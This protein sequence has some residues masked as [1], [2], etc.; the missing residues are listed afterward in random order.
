MLRKRIRA[1]VGRIRWLDR[2]LTVR[3]AREYERAYRAT[4]DWYHSR[5]VECGLRWDEAE[6]RVRVLA[7]AALRG[8]APKKW[9]AVHAFFIDDGGDYTAMQ[10]LPA[11]NRAG[12]CTIVD[13]KALAGFIPA[14]NLGRWKGGDPQLAAGLLKQIERAQVEQALDVI[15]CSNSAG[16][17]SNQAVAELARLGVPMVS[18]WSDDKT[19]FCKHMGGVWGNCPQATL[20]D[21]CW[22]TSSACLPWYAVEGGRA[23][24]M[25]E[26]AAPETFH[27][28]IPKTFSDEVSF[29]GMKYGVRADF[30]SFLRGRGIPVATYGR[31]WGGES[32]AWQDMARVFCSSRINLGLPWV[33]QS[34][35]IAH[36][37]GRDFEVPMSGGLYLTG[38]HEE[39]SRHY[40]VGQEIMCYGSWDGCVEVIRHLV[41]NPDLA[42]RIRRAGKQRALRDHTWDARFKKLMG[43]MGIIGETQNVE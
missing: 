9:G 31:G 17:L 11:L 2:L 40:R 7:R 37:K 14:G 16:V 15:F 43:F 24:C 30:I 18:Y 34:R 12:R 29:L 21:L 36:L 39:L 38:Y 19:N 8:R 41:A 5:A 33:T 23:I 6:T 28:E 20:F 27:A 1:V 22:T 3:R 4:C 32:V 35:T 42:D 13:W 10:M 26:G 25:P